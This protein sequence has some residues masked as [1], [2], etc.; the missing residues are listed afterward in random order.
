MQKQFNK[1][2]LATIIGAFLATTVQG[3]TDGSAGVAFDQRAHGNADAEQALPSSPVAPPTTDAAVDTVVAA[4]DQAAQQISTATELAGTQQQGLTTTL[5]EADASLSAT[6]GGA[7]TAAG[8]LSGAG[9]GV[10]EQ[11][12]AIGTAHVATS[13]LRNTQMAIADGANGGHDEIADGSS[14]AAQLLQVGQTATAGLSEQASAVMQSEVSPANTVANGAAE[15]SQSVIGQ[16]GLSKT[17]P[18]PASGSELPALPDDNALPTAPDTSLPT[19]EVT[20]NSR[21]QTDVSASA[22]FA[23]NAQRLNLDTQ[24][25]MQT[26]IGLSSTGRGNANTTLGSS[27]GGGVGSITSGASV[28]GA[29]SLLR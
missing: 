9:A 28:L 24:Q 21:A 15:L 27:I 8:E 17:T 16:V 19:P 2:L 3:A 18:E 25:R 10:Q 22:G 12:N 1:L 4:A 7:L 11:V 26:D 6:A 5:D 23:A 20:I 29:G 13:A 14:V